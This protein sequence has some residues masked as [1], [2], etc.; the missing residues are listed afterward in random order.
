M[1]DG[2]SSYEVAN[3]FSSFNPFFNSFIGDPMLSPM[4]DCEH[5]PLYLSG[6]SGASKDSYN[7]LLSTRT[8]WHLQ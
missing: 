8:S 1:V 2:C 5:L 6:S 3:T 7:K 4:V